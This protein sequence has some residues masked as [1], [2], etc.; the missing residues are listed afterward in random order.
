MPS[1]LR[2]AG[3]DAD[4][5]RERKQERLVATA[6][7]KALNERTPTWHLLDRIVGTH[8]DASSRCK[9]AHMETCCGMRDQL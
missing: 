9:H 6:H 5:S 8:A 4:I 3:F 7:A 2:A 1:M